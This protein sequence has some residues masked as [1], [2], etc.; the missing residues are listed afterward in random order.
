MWYLCEATGASH[1][2]CGPITVQGK[3]YMTAD[4][5][6]YYYTLH[7]VIKEHY[8]KVYAEGKMGGPQIAV[9]YKGR[10]YAVESKHYAYCLDIVEAIYNRDEEL[11]GAMLNSVLL[12][13]QMDLYNTQHPELVSQRV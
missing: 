5:G 6:M 12:D 10:W 2:Y 3:T 4:A 7:S 1:Y 13:I 11:V 9:Q 8:F